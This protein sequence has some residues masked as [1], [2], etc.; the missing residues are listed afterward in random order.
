MTTEQLINQSI[1]D[2]RE[3]KV[4]RHWYISELGSCMRGQYLKR[5]W[6]ET[7]ERDVPHFDDRTLRIFSVGDIFESW[8]ADLMPGEKQVPVE[9]IGLDISGYVDNVTDDFVYEYKTKHSRAFWYMVDGYR[10]VKDEDGRTRRTWVEGEG[11]NRQHQIQLWMYLSLLHREHGKL[12]YISKDDL[13]IHEYDVMLYD[14]KLRDETL[15]IIEIL[16]KAWSTKTPPPRAE[17]DTWQAK[18]CRVHEWCKEYD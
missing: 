18:Y 16:N 1:R 12:V 14:E 13:A 3:P 17:D 7:K 9:D 4:Q 6:G 11:P 8:I 15:G 5:L 10:M 2:K